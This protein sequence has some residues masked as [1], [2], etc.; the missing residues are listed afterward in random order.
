[1][2]NDHYKDKPKDN[3]VFDSNSYWIL[4]EGLRSMATVFYFT[5]PRAVFLYIKFTFKSEVVDRDAH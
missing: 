5:E 1:M 4:R 3:T 2:A